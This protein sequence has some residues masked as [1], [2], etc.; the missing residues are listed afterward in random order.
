[1]SDTRKNKLG[2][3]IRTYFLE[4]FLLVVALIE[5]YP[6]FLVFINSFKN[7]REFYRNPLSF[8]SHFSLQNFMEAAQRINFFSALKNS[9]VILVLTL[10]II[11]IFSSLAAYPIAKRATKYNKM[12]Y[13]YF[14]AGI[15]LPLQIAMVPLVKIIRSLHLVNSYFSVVFISAAIALPLSISIYVGFF[16]TIPDELEEAAFI[17][18]CNMV[19]AFIKIYMPLLKAT[20]GTI[21]ILQSIGIWND[22]LLTSLF[23]TKSYMKTVTV[24][25]FSFVGKYAT[26][27]D[28]IFPSIFLSMIPL[29][30]CFLIA[31]KSFIKGIMSGALKG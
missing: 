28:M 24:S 4:I 26:Q 25:L 11:V 13:I 14:L 3:V 18:G 30:L 12:L 7:S 2:H 19:T 27:W 31:N 10:T 1:M 9:V 8:P 23:L 29:V 17:D 21:V 15:I 5:I 22:F 20:T 16:K 6:V